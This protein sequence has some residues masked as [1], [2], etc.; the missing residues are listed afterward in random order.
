MLAAFEEETFLYYW[1]LFCYY[2][3]GHSHKVLYTKISQIYP[4]QKCIIYL[5]GECFICGGMPA[6]FLKMLVTETLSHIQCCGEVVI[7]VLLGEP[8]CN[9][10]KSINGHLQD[11]LILL[12]IVTS[13]FSIGI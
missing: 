8:V 2:K 13:Y 3:T 9:T 6:D 12:K 7:L 1:F 4:F 10:L 11:Y 5:F